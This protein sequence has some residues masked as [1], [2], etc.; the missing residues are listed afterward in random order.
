M[1]NYSVFQ[2]FKPEYY[3]EDP[4]PHVIIPNAID[5]ELYSELERTFPFDKKHPE[6]KKNNMRLNIGC[7]EMLENNTIT[8][9]WRNF[10]E[11][12]S[13][14]GF[15]TDYSKIFDEAASKEYDLTLSNLKLIRDTRSSS[16]IKKEGADFSIDCRVAVNTPNRKFRSSGKTQKKRGD[17]PQ[18]NVVRGPHVDKYTALFYGLLY[19]RSTVDDS[20]GGSLNLYRFK[21]KEYLKENNITKY[22]GR[23]YGY[24]P[25]DI[26]EVNKDAIEIA[27]TVD[28]SRNTFVIALNSKKAVHGVSPRDYTK[29]PRRFVN[30]IA[31]YKEALFPKFIPER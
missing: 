18:A 22:F 15:W 27:K 11:Y 2:N 5:D 31:R 26:T 29:H 8:D 9:H 3:F 24:S 30:F 20:E 25:N 12:N 14:D 16:K 19:M 13:G 28:Y 21:D 6:Y 4:F 10:I 17:Q 1:T 7:E 23:G